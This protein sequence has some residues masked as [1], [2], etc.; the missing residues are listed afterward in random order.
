MKRFL[1]CEDGVGVG[2]IYILVVA[3]FGCVLVWLP[4]ELL[5]E[6]GM[7]LMC[8]TM[9]LFI[10]AFLYLKIRRSDLPRPYQVPGSGLFF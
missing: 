4:Y 2:R 6:F 7:L 8:V 3:V 10:Y 9:V 5:V 1:F